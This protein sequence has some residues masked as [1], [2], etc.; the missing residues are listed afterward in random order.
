MPASLL[1]ESRVVVGIFP[2]V[3]LLVGGSGNMAVY[4]HILVIPPNAKVLPPKNENRLPPKHY[5][6]IA[7]LP[8]NT[9]LFWFHRFRQKST[10][11][12][13]SRQKVRPTLNIAKKVP[14]LDTAQKLSPTPD[15]AQKVPP[16]R[17]R[18]YWIPPKRYRVQWIPPKKYRLF[19]SCSFFVLC[20]F[21]FFGYFFCRTSLRT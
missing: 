15:T 2:A 12:S 19:S 16:K 1:K 3:K 13:R 6:G 20:S 21:W 14:I 7:L 8:K 9:A 18:R 4:R 17:H 5:R 11:N 10:A